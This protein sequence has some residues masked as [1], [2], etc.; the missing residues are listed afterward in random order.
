MRFEKMWIKH[1][2][3]VKKKKK[4]VKFWEE[5]WNYWEYPLLLLSTSK[6]E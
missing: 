2:G 4:E 6:G 5:Y 1:S 3:T